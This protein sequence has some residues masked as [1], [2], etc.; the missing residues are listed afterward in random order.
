MGWFNAFAQAAIIGTVRPYV[1]RELPGWGKLY[2]RLIGT[3]AHD[4]FWA[5]QPP[6]WV[7]GKLHGYEMRVD[8]RRWS[9]RATFFLGR[10]YDLPTQLLMMGVVRR[11]DTVVDIGA[12]EGMISL[13]LSRL[14]GPDGRVI[15]FEPNPGPRAV[16]EANLERNRI[17]NTRVHA[18]G[19]ADE[20][21]TL[22]LFVPH[23]NSGEGSFGA[24]RY[25]ADEG[26]TIACPIGVGDEMLAGEI[27]AV[28]KIDVEGFELR[29]LRG[30]SKTM[31]QAKPVIVM[32]MVASHLARA[33]AS[34]A[35]LMEELARHG[36]VGH[37]LGIER[38]GGR[39]ALRLI[40]VDPAA[41][42]T[43]GDLVWTVPGSAG[44]DAIEA[45]RQP[46]G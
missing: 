35:A 45:I 44:H 46:A 11:G 8:I 37:R 43:D 12:N 14:A 28:I 40:P 34:P 38:V 27:P 19:L 24:R 17:M 41:E 26:E 6:R 4:G 25:D 3:Y 16:F 31:A 36:Y 39:Q 20:P 5:G 1:S 30:L 15:A 2:N 22:P 23:M 33:D 13:L 7:R 42:W 18:C 9:N 29:V 10:F 21:G 32:E